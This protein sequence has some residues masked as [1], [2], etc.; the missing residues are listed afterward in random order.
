MT[1][2]KQVRTAAIT[3]PTELE[4]VITRDFDAPRRLVWDAHVRPEHI[5]RWMLGPP[6]WTMT[7]CEVDLRPG[8]SWHFVWRHAGGE[9]MS[10]TGV[11][12]EIAPPERLVNTEAWG[13]DWAETLS[14]MILTEA[15]GATTMRNTMRYP[16]KEARDRALESGMKD[17]LDI[18]YDRLDEVLRSLA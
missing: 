4:L 17:G 3:T 5:P 15:G 7:V 9:E 13:G 10:M 16:S 6:G 1:P 11:Y 18:S 14:T 12:R 2:G 8:G